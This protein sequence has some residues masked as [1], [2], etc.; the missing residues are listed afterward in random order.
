MAALRGKS[1]GRIFISYRRIDADYAASWLYEHL[2]ARFGRD[3]V[4][5]DVDSIGIGD[6]FAKAINQA[7]EA[8]NLFLALIGEHWITIADD[9][10][11]R[12]LDDPNDFVRLEI[13]AALRHHVRVI[14]VLLGTEMPRADQLPPSLVGLTR[15]QA[16]EISPRHF[17]LASNKLIGILEKVLASDRAQREADK[18]A[19][20]EALRK[21]ISAGEYNVVR[22]VFSGGDDN[23]VSGDLE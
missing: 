17:D 6:D 14:P 22:G 12:R 8:C 23:E 18:R 21:R 20:S 2:I 9:N 4:F 13:E 3:Y 5:K 11:N 1:R 10:G 19:L 16:Y 7:V 15:F